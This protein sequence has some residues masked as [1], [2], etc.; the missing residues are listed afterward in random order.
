VSAIL[1]VRALSALVVCLL[2]PTA[3]SAQKL[4][5]G[6]GPGATPAVRVF[7][8]SGTDTTFLAYAAAF[9]GGVRVAL[10]D[11]TGDGVL[12]IITGAGP[13]GGPH[14]RVWN[15]TDLTEVGG[16]FAYD[17]AFPGGVFVAAGDVNGDGRADIITGAG[18]G[19]GPHVRVWS[20]AD[21]T[22][23]GGFFAYDPAFP[24]GVSV[25]AGDVNG[26]G[27]ADIITG[28][29][30][31]GGPHV[32]VWNA[33][34]FTEIGGFFAY[35]PAFP[36][37]V[38]VAAAD[39]D[40]DGRA[41]I[42]TGAGPGGGP[43]VR[44]WSGADFTEIGGFFAYDPAFPGGVTVGTVDL[45]RDG[46]YEL[47]TGPAT[48][49]PSL[50]R[51]WTGT[52]FVLFGEYVAFDSPG[53]GVSIGSTGGSSALR[54]TSAN[55]TTFS[56]DTPG[57]FAVTTTGGLAVPAL[58]VTGGLPTGVTFTDNGDRTGTLAGT[59]AAATGGSY[60]LTFAATSSGLPPVTQAFTLTINQAPAITS[61][62]A[63]TFGLGGLGTFTVTTTGFP[64]PTLSSTGALPAG[65]TFTANANGTATLAGTPTAGSGGTYPLT[66]TAVNGAGP[67]AT[68]AFVLT[69]NTSPSFTSANAAT[70][71]VGTA[72]SFAITTTAS[73]TVTSISRTGALPTGVTFTDNGN[74]TAT[75]AGTP[76]AG[77]GGTYPL[78][79]T[80]ANGVG[81]NAVQTFTLT[82][83]QAPA[84]TSASAT[85]FVVG[86]AG[87]FTVTTTGVP[88]PA[89]TRGGVALPAGVTFVDNGNGTATLS[90]TPAAGTA[91]TYALTFTATNTVGATAPQAFTLTVI[92]APTFTSANTTTFTVGSPGTFTIT[93]VG[94]P[95]PTLTVTGALP[96]GVTFLDNGN[97]TGTLSGTPA[98]GTGGT[99]AIT[100]TAANGIP[101]N[102]VQTFTLNVN[103]AP[104]ITSAASTTL[105][106]GVAG[107]FTVTTSGF[108]AP[109]LAIGG[110]ALPSG[111]MFVDNGNGTGTLS[112]MPAVGTGGTYAI[113]F[114]ATNTAGTTAPQAFTLTVNQP[115]AITSATSTTF[116]VGSA[117]SFTV[118]TSAFPVATITRTGAAPPAGVTFVD[119]GDGT[120]TLSGTPAAGTAGA[121]A[122]TF[123]AANGVLPNAVQ[124]FTL[125]VNQPPAITS[126][127][128]DTFIVGAVDSFTVT[129]TGFPTPTVTH[130][131]GTLPAG[132]TFTSATRV[133]SGPA[134]QIGAFPLQFTAA[135]GVVPNAVQ[136]FT[137]NVVC[138][139][140]TV[141]PATMTDGLY[142]TAYGGVDFN[143]TGSTG[144]S[145]TWAAT[146]LPAGLNIAPITGIVSGTPTN[147]VL[148]GA[149]VVTVTDNFGCQGT[150]NT[151]ITVRPTTDNENYVGGVGNTQYVVA[152]AGPST[153][154]V[155]VND[156]VKTGDNGPGPLSV[157][158]GPAVNGTVA[159]GP[160]DGTF[161]YTPNVNFAGPTD[162]FSYTLTDGNGV[163]NSATVTINLTGLVWY[164]N[165]SGGNGDGR[166]HAPFNTLANAAAPSATGSI[167]YVHSGVGTTPGNLAMDA[168]QTLFGQGAPFTLNNLIIAAGARPTLSG[169]VTLANNDAVT[170]V[171]FSGATPA[172]TATGVT[173]P[174]TI[175]QVG[176]TGGTN[177]LSLTNVSGS[178]TVTNA[179]FTNTSGSEVLIN[180]GIGTVSVGAIISSNVGRSIDVLNRT[181]GT[182]TFSGT[183][184]DTGQ[185]VFLNANTGSTINF[186]GGLALSTGADPG[187]TAT[188]GGTVNVTGSGNTIATTTGTAL[189]VSNTTI[190]ASGATFRSISANGATNGIVLNS[191]GAG[192]LIV[193]GNS[194]GNCGG[195]VTVNPVG[196]PATV[197]APDTAD[198]TGGTIQN[199]TSHAISLTGTSNTSLTRMRVLNSGA[200]G[201]LA[202]NVNGF[203]LARSLITDASGAAGDRGIEMGDFS[204]G[205]PVNGTITIS[206]STIG[207]TAHDNFGIGIA[208]G[209][210]AWSITNTVFTGSVQ[211]SGLNFEVRN[212]TVTS[213]VINGSVFQNQF[214]DGMQM[215]PA[216][217]VSASLT[218]TIQNSTFTNNN[219]HLDLN[220]DG[221]GTTTYRVLDNTFRSAQ[222][223]AVNFFSSA[224]QAPAT[225]GTL[226]GRFEGNVIGSAAI[227]SSGSVLG[228]GIRINI[229]GGVAARVLVDS[230]TIRQMPNGR[231]IE[232]ISRNGTGG[233]DVTVTN[234]QVNND[235]VTTPEN[236]GF[237]LASLFMQ[238]NCVTVCNTLRAD[239]RGNT[240]PATPP[241]GELLSA[242][243]AIIE[244]STSTFQLVDTGAASASCS[245][246]LT[247][248][249]TGSSGATAGCALIPG[250]INMPPP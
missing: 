170:A 250:P 86:A 228:N 135:N 57:T 137:L 148:N 174:I 233:A 53:S 128:T 16:F 232:V 133:L 122:F 49:T 39:V 217:G 109:A 212:A 97:G 15:G 12:D 191:T 176:V 216:S 156:N 188:N 145:F 32:R 222:S 84:I 27:L 38:N 160:T 93:A 245:A 180:Q 100:F 158:F 6:S 50:V 178:V 227:A 31:G 131:S 190:G 29:G 92:N 13:G 67:D 28:A 51:L 121:Y 207:P 37:G 20:G 198:C 202:S 130:T 151:T 87:S 244:T 186:T 106:I 187:F 194:A 143:Q 165:N 150:L 103:Q 247:E 44:V 132:V 10:G 120:G 166:S 243:L 18:P 229:N 226:N 114:T 167:I 77:T 80:A 23:I 98:G 248:T 42:V 19:G 136:N 172:L 204:T 14:V 75:L 74:G 115:P 161:T 235:F 9:P 61:A 164:V 34:D 66:I 43:H 69:V 134:T 89:I 76:A 141:T 149:V 116:T 3:A 71:T 184:T 65:V 200:D 218:A 208:S 163:T 33:A 157:V 182:V 7:D 185:G 197:G 189:N 249:N 41:D 199:T 113:T 124:A 105:S 25:A 177:A 102:G 117:G 82:V 21:F 79:L 48:G 47:V 123:T 144:S 63:T 110:A 183:I 111:V 153:P 154:H 215:Q 140:I 11:V 55:T 85:T 146:G 221:T 168:T 73:P 169:T 5:T 45:D 35:D 56:V 203:T 36:G 213:F 125:N 30:P 119:N 237:A 139:A 126:G 62:A 239:V 88:T 1:R 173:Q 138:P 24:G 214:A 127:N 94:A 219:L 223:H 118:T 58:S 91:G 78:T 246:Q 210:S 155:L 205:T 192:A 95:T 68:Q 234:N 152:A 230:N 40:G 22:E 193:T 240:V 99:Y 211:N 104:A 179:T 96:S 108:P 54:F 225:G 52:T 241:N 64:V 107:S 209:T 162:T 112:G 101:P 2:F 238:S 59:P 175:D 181:G 90:G 220:H 159:E 70:F 17:P 201:I 231:G 60:Q 196:T 26:D 142:L 4:V 72:G 206:N 46:R 129:T 195:T 224:V 242:Q 147:T 8:A 236:G 171:N 81:T 83:R